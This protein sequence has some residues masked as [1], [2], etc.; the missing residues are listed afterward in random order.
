RGSAEEQQEAGGGQVASP[1]KSTHSRLQTLLSSAWS[2]GTSGV[3]RKRNSA[4]FRSCSVRR[5]LKHLHFSLQER[6]CA[7]GEARARSLP[8]LLTNHRAGGRR[9]G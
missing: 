4:G 2:S 5:K 3:N 7:A 6:V 9:G 1:R 8:S